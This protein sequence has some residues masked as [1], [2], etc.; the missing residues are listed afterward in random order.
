[1]I[2]TYR[3]FTYDE[4]IFYISEYNDED[5]SYYC[6]FTWYEDNWFFENGYVLFNSRPAT[7]LEIIKYKISKWLNK[8]LKK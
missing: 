1:M 2:N 7:F 3:A 8:K 6:E 5:K 4:E